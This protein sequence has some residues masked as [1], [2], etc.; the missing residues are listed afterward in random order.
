[1]C[2]RYARW[3]VEEEL[4]EF[5]DFRLPPEP[6]PVT[7]NAAPQSIQPIIRLSP[8]TGETEIVMARW[9]L[10][11]YWAKDAKVGFTTI[12]ARSEELASKPAFRESFKSKRCLVPA[13]CYYEWQTFS[14]NNKQPYA[15]GMQTGKPFALAGLWDKWQAPDGTVIES[16]TVSTISPNALTAPLHN[17][18]PCILE[19]AEYA[20]WLNAGDAADVLRSY[21]EEKMRC[22]PVGKAVGNVRNDDPSL[23]QPIA[24]EL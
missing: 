4:E 10:I 22:W 18:M 23:C 20:R 5:S 16:F 19:P 15:I 13:N 14:K 1:M 17:R 24:F 8:K 7:Y 6:L 12:N 3:L 11:P 21:P 9:G 2:A